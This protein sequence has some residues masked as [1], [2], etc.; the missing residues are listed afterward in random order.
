MRLQNNKE[1]IENS[2]TTVYVLVADHK[3]QDSAQLK[4]KTKKRYSENC[5]LYVSRLLGQFPSSCLNTL[6]CRDYL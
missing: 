3:T 6:D 4:K 5:S 2:I 1:I